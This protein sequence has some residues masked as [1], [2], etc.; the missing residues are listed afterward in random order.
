MQSRKGAAAEWLS[1][2]ILGTPRPR[3]ERDKP[4]ALRRD[5]DLIIK[6]L[7]A[8]SEIDRSVKTLGV[9]GRLMR[10]SPSASI[11]VDAEDHLQFLVESY[12]GEVYILSERCDVFL[13]FLERAYRKDARA[14]Q[15]RAEIAALRR[16]LSE[17]LKPIIGVRGAHVHQSRHDDFDVSRLSTLRLLTSTNSQFARIYATA[18]RDV[19]RR[20]VKWVALNNANIQTF[21]DAYFD[22]VYPIVFNDADEFRAP[23]VRQSRSS[24]T[25]FRSR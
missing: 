4:A 18:R 8:Y 23:E 15:V 14:E 12:L 11:G 16:S 21:V 24:T 17:T 2:V 10:R 9:I 5:D 1:E 19:R 25:A 3:A 22:G 6:I 20:K 13:T 7:R